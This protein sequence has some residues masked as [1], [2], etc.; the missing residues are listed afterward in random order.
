MSSIGF[1]EHML[2]SPLLTN[3][4]LPRFLGRIMLLGTPS[5]L[6]WIIQKE[7]G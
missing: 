6:K 1:L 4:M 5:V 3:A 7:N 2:D